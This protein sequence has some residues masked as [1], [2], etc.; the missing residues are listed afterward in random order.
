M[1]KRILR[2]AANDQIR[3]SLIFAFFRLFENSDLFSKY[4]SM[5]VFG[6]EFLDLFPVSA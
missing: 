3:C 6:Q 5:H 4:F 2:I 1:L